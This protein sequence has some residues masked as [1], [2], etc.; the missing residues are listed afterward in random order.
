[1]AIHTTR[2]S[3]PYLGKIREVQLQLD[4]PNL[5]TV[6]AAPYHLPDELH[7]STPAQAK[8]GRDIAEAFLTSFGL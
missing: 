4:L 1:V 5:V 8:L 7:L 6:D 2:K 3:L